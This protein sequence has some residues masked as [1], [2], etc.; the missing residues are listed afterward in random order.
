MDRS[1]IVVGGGS[2]GG[3]IAVNL[4]YMKEWNAGEWDRSGVVGLVN[5]WGSPRPDWSF[6]EVNPEDP[7]A[8]IVHGTQDASVAFSN[9]L[10]LVK[11]LESQGVHHELVTVEG[12][13]HTPHRRMDN[14]V[15]YIAR[16]LFELIRK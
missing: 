1:R 12:A 15:Q 2:A 14:F 4:C 13:G 7:P 3:M 6:Y 10:D 5:L 8:L 9:A 11:E 16:F